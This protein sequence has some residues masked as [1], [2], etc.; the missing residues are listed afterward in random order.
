MLRSLVLSILL[1]V[2]AQPAFA[3]LSVADLKDDSARMD[4]R[5]LSGY[6][7]MMET[8]DFFASLHDS[9][10]HGAYNDLQGAHAR[11][12]AK[13]AELEKAIAASETKQGT[14][15]LGELQ[16]AGEVVSAKLEAYTNSSASAVEKI[17][18]G[19]G[20]LA[21]LICGLG[22]LIFRSRKKPD[23]NRRR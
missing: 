22:Y 13:K 7:R 6:K 12:V 15:L 3:Q 1:L 20:V 17:Q 21:F 4:A 8:R 18:I 14:K 10:S 9:V 23:P 5:W 19:L 11:Y 16:D 2:T